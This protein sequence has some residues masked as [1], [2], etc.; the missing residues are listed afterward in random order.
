MPIKPENKGLYPANWKQ[1]RTSILARA[2]NC[3]EMCGVRNSAFIFRLAHDPSV[4]VYYD[5]DNDRFYRPDGREL[6]ESDLHHGFDV[7]KQP[8]RVVLTIAHLDHNPTNNAHENLKA[9]CQRC[10]LKHDAKHHAQ[11]ARRTRQAKK[12]S[13]NQSELL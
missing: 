3:C 1:I 10:H 5:R 4:Y 9:L 6:R 11:N 12:R 13:P 7:S 8:S 2:G